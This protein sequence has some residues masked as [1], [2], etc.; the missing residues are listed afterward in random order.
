M[1][2]CL[3]DAPIDVTIHG[4][5]QLPCK[6]VFHLRCGLASCNKIYSTHEHPQC[7][8]CTSSA[9]KENTIIPP[10]NLMNM[11]NVISLEEAYTMSETKYLIDTTSKLDEKIRGLKPEDIKFW[12]DYI[13]FTKEEFKLYKA[14][15]S[16][17]WKIA[18][19]FK[20][21]AAHLTAI[22]NRSFRKYYK[23]C[24]ETDEFNEYK[25]LVSKVKKIT[26]QFDRYVDEYID[27]YN[28]TLTQFLRKIGI[29]GPDEQ[30]SYL[31]F[32]DGNESFISFFNEFDKL[33]DKKNLFKK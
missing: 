3:C 27:P 16:R 20:E 28:I 22:Y 1:D 18:K 2:C 14:R 30:I 19:E 31:S 8:V 33:Y 25:A 24:L 15:N 11:E 17:I 32:S 10:T 23:Q 12:K 6:H 7:R 21:E 5:M 13:E 29:L 9:A 4:Y 26:R